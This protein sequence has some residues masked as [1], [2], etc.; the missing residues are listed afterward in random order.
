MDGTCLVVGGDSRGLSRPGWDG[1]GRD[2]NDQEWPLVALV[3]G[4]AAGLLGHNL[5][6]LILPSSVPPL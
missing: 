3:I 6:D 5:H 2:E 4:A 1:S